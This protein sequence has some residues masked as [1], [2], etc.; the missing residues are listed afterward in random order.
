WGYNNRGQLG[1]GTIIDKS[2]PTQTGTD[3]DWAVVSAG[4]HHT[5]ALKSDGTLWTWGSN[6][7]GELGDGTDIDKYL[8]APIEAGARWIAIA[9]GNYFTVTVKSDGTLWM[10]GRNWYGQLGTDTD[11]IEIAGG[12]THTLALKSDGTLWAWGDNYFGQLGDGTD[13]RKNIP[14]RIGTDT[15]WTAVS[16]GAGH[17]LAL[18]SAPTN[19]PPTFSNLN[20]YK[21]DGIILIPENNIT[22]EDN[23]IF[24]ATV[25]DSDNDKVKLQIELKEYNQPF[26]GLNLIES[27]FVS[28][29][30]ETIIT[31]TGL[32][33]GQYYWRARA[34][35]DKGNASN[36]QEFGTA[37]NVDFEVKLVPLYTQVMSDFPS[38]TVTD[39]WARLDYGI[40]YYSNC[41]TK[42][43]LNDPND[44]IMYSNIGRCGCAI[45]SMV[46][47]G[48]YY[49]INI[50]TDGTNADPANIN[51]WLT[52]N[53]GYTKDGGLYWGKAI[54]YLGFIENGVKK[55][56]LSLDHHN[57]TS[58]LT[59]VDNYITSAKPAIAY[60]S[61]FGHYFVVDDKLQNTYTIKDPRWYNTKK[62]NDSE[63]FANEVRG[64]NNYFDTANLFS[65]LETPK[66]LTASIYLYL[67][68]P[69]EL[70]IV[71][72]LGRKLGKD[73]I[74]NTV[75]NEIPD[76]SYTQEGPII[77]SDT[78]LDPNQIHKTKV[79]YIPTPVEGNY[80]IRVIGTDT[81]IYE[82]STLI[83]DNQ[84]ARRVKVRSETLKQI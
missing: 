65:Y 38:R 13:A 71:D 73:P 63:N 58:T 12:G 84:G 6:V 46:M 9:T 34:V 42:K 41:L 31:R 44:S 50:G 64:Y 3:T 36:W 29:T 82:I 54:E 33:D 51:T 32:I 69:A 14:T 10:W 83:Y 5:A 74:A 26:N 25:S 68:S 60:S 2:I 35:D 28:S 62:L 45:T 27:G 66:K 1:D 53:K 49:D 48:R 17:S 67:A 77:T 43:N 39:R 55:V 52:T 40:G 15:D 79:I 81:G 72:P 20:Q 18:K 22:T 59:V 61:K 30:S 57:A 23:V 78:S 19:Q 16:A 4:A 76:G 24:K 21:S 47:V 37:G 80:D 11:W 56:R 75:Y 70:L 8:P 7:S